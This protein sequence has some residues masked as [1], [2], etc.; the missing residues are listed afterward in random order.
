MSL[1]IIIPTFKNVEFLPELFDSIDKCNF[2]GEYEVLIGIDSCEDTLKYVYENQF[3]TNFRFFFFLENKGP[4]LIKNTLSD[5]S[6]FDKLFFFD[7]DDVMMPDLISEIDSKLNT[8]VVV[9]PKY[10]DFKDQNGI[11]EYV[12]KKPTFGEGVF[13]IIKELLIEM[14]GFEGWQVAADSDFMGRLYKTNKNIL[15]TSHI[16]FYRRIHPNSL[17]IHPRTGLSSALRGNYYHMSK[18]KTIENIK[19]EEFLKSNYK[20]VDVEDKILLKSQNEINVEIEISDYEKKKLKHE[21]IADIFL[22]KPKN[23]KTDVKPKIINYNH[24]NQNTNY[25]ISS[26]LSVALKKA[27]LENIKKNHRR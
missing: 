11:R 23:I 27:K 19:N 2:T 10:M 7:S 16:L 20:V 3:P 17:T 22:N 25:P 15:H 1:S 9:K 24:I 8:Y 12:G 4:Y 5:L 21:S 14:N 13:G 18:K 26:Q 6:S